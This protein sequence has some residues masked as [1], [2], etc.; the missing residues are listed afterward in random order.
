MVSK[1]T[2]SKPRGRCKVPKKDKE[3]IIFRV[4]EEP[5]HWICDIQK[6]KLLNKSVLKSSKLKRAHPESEADITTTLESLQNQIVSPRL[7]EASSC[8][9]STK[10]LSWNNVSVFYF[11]RAVGASSVP[12]DGAHPLGLAMKHVDYEKV[13]L[14]RYGASGTEGASTRLT[15]ANKMESCNHQASDAAPRDKFTMSP[16]VQNVLF[17]SQSQK[18][19]SVPLSDNIS[20]VKDGIFQHFCSN[21][22]PK[23]MFS[24]SA[25]TQLRRSGA[26]TNNNPGPSPS[27]L[28]K[29]GFPWE[30]ETP[31]I[32]T[33][34]QKRRVLRSS[35]R[36]KKLITEFSKKLNVQEIIETLPKPEQALLDAISKNCLES[37]NKHHTTSSQSDTGCDPAELS[38]PERPAVMTPASTV[39][40]PASTRVLRRSKRRLEESGTR[41]MRHLSARD[42]ISLLRQGGVGGG[43]REESEEI[44]RI[45]DS[46][47]RGG[48]CECEDGCQPRTCECHLNSI[49]CH[50][51]WAG[52]P[53][54]CLAT[55][56]NPLGRRVFDHLAVAL[57]FI[58]TMF[59]AE[60]VM[61][62]GE[63]EGGG[64]K[65]RLKR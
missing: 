3:K 36:D 15:R 14:A 7:S 16:Q 27:K 9:G 23:R 22:G 59:T 11:P 42:R 64:S 31:E 56:A 48:G 44:S 49:P 17:S 24:Q 58:N 13:K 55:C 2:K 63:E 5:T 39:M 25:M 53:C 6:C 46:R 45:Q 43:G 21:P 62:L 19:Q 40:T 37:Y 12:R 60:G 38:S 4:I 8:S 10:K 65:K 30:P 34:N 28:L 41:G 18:I 20:M 26:F 35:E 29:P 51:E 61:D 52:F 33:V 32:K 50:L 54:S 47:S 57:H 1:F